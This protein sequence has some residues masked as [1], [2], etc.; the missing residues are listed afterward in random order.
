M[1]GETFHTHAVLPTLAV[2]MRI[3]SGLNATL[4]TGPWCYGS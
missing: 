4:P 2:T 1:A 3:P